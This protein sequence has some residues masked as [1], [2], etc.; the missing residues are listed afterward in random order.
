MARDGSEAESESRLVHV[1]VCVHCGC[2]LKREEIDS[3]EFGKKA[4]T[5]KASP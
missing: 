3:Q 4:R 5:K 2:L 1:H